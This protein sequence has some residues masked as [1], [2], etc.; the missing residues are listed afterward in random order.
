VAPLWQGTITFSGD[1]LGDRSMTY[2][3]HYLN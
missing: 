2:V 1:S 3:D